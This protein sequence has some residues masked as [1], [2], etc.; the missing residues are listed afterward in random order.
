MSSN[1]NKHEQTAESLKGLDSILQ[2]RTR[3]GICVL[4]ADVDALSFSRLKELLE[5]TDGN[6]GASLRKLEEAS[7]VSVKKEFVDRKPV[8]WYSLSSAGRNN[9]AAH[10]SA[11]EQLVRQTKFKN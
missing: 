1:P 3:L 6:L 10:L 4:L 7:Y 5:E 2:N 11:L 8:T 9:L